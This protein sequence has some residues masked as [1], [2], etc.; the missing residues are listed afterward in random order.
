MVTDNIAMYDI[1]TS[2]Y[3]DSVQYT[4]VENIK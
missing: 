4:D 1:S 3:T 2:V